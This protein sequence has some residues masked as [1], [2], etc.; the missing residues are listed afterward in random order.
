MG[1]EG[2]DEPGVGALGVGGGTGVVA[3]ALVAVIV[4]AMA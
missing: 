4:V 1:E 3:P 2:V